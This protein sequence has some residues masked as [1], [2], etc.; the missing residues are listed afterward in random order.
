MRWIVM[1]VILLSGAL[2]FSFAT[3]GNNTSSDRSIADQDFIKHA[4]LTAKNSKAID[5]TLKNVNILAEK[6]LVLTRET[7]EQKELI[8]VQARVSGNALKVLEANARIDRLLTERI[9]ALE[10]KI[11]P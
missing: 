11:A 6:L 9:E 3:I 2:I 10:T 8:H 1:V 4:E 5:D 7:A